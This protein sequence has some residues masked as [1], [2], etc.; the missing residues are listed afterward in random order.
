MHRDGIAT[1]PR[2]LAAEP[3]L[4]PGMARKKCNEFGGKPTSIRVDNLRRGKSVG[5]M[6]APQS[7]APYAKHVGRERFAGGK[8]ESRFLGPRPAHVPA[9]GPLPLPNVTSVARR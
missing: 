9:P 4:Q 6:F 7:C 1:P 3:A 2:A 5:S 8:S